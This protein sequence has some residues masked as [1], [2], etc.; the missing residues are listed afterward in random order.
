MANRF[1]RF[2]KRTG[3]AV[4]D[5]AGPSTYSSESPAATAEPSSITTALSTF[6]AGHILRDGE[7]VILMI[8]PSK[9]FIL[10]NSLRFLAAT[11]ILVALAAMFE[12]QLPYSVKQY[13]ELG[14]MAGAGRLMWATL[15]WM[16]KL[17]ILTDLRILALT[18]VFTIDVFDCT[19]RKVA[20]TL[21]DVTFKEQLFRVG[22]II[23]IPQDDECPLGQW[24]MVAR[25]KFVHA[26]I[27]AQISRAK[28]G[29]IDC[30]R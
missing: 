16:G 5:L 21:L 26:Q 17:Y 9:W 6:L 1:S 13:V 30:F 28:H 10:L 12:E 24:Q 14:I 19:L 25:P 7:L 20:R 8:R 29:G 18:G 3:E 2:F 4:P 22:T 11:A 23:V 27:L 15:Q